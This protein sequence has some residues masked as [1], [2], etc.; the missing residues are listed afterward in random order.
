MDFMFA[1]GVQVKNLEKQLKVTFTV[2]ASLPVVRA[3]MQTPMSKYQ[4]RERGIGFRVRLVC[5][6]W[7]I[8]ECAVNLNDLEAVNS[9][10]RRSL[11]D[12]NAAV[13]S[14]TA[15]KTQFTGFLHGAKQ[16]TTQ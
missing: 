10:L 4:R 8:V 5:L 1:G 9:S 13:I 11:V 15:V 14:I 3:N 12:Y 6:L 7:V 16:N 2:K